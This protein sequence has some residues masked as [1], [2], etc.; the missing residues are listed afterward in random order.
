M[1]EN[2]GMKNK[3]SVIVNEEKKKS[4][5]MSGVDFLDKNIENHSAEILEK[6]GA[7]QEWIDYNGL[8]DAVIVN[9]N[10]LHEKE[11]SYFIKKKIERMLVLPLDDLDEES[12]RVFIKSNWDYLS[13][14]IV[15]GGVI[16][17]RTGKCFEYEELEGLN[18]LNRN[19]FNE[20]DFERFFSLCRNVEPVIFS[21]Y[22]KDQYAFFYEDEDIRNNYRIAPVMFEG[23]LSSYRYYSRISGKFCALYDY[24]KGRVLKY[25][26][27]DAQTEKNIDDKKTRE[28]S[29]KIRDMEDELDYMDLKLV[30]EEFGYVNKYIYFR[31]KLSESVMADLDNKFGLTHLPDELD[32]DFFNEDEFNML[33]EKNRQEIKITE[34]KANLELLRKSLV[35]VLEER[36]MSNVNENAGFKLD[37]MSFISRRFSSGVP[38][39]SSERLEKYMGSR[40]WLPDDLVAE[41]EKN[42]PVDFGTYVINDYPYYNKK[43]FPEDMH[44]IEIETADHFLK[45][46][47]EVN[48]RIEK[49]LNGRL[50]LKEVSLEDI[51]AEE[52]FDKNNL[53]DNK[54]VE[55]FANYRSLMNL[56]TRRNI[57]VEFGIKLSDFSVREQ[58]QFVNFLSAKSEKEVIMV[59][60]FL[61]QGA[62]KKNRLKAFLSLESGEKMSEVIMNIG[63]QLKNNPEIADNLF[64]EYAKIVDGAQKTAEEIEKIYAEIFLKKSLDRNELMRTILKKASELLVD[65]QKELK[66]SNGQDADEV[67]KKIVE[68]LKSQEKNQKKY[69]ADI[70]QAL[71]ILIKKSGDIFLAKFSEALEEINK[72]DETKR[73][74]FIVISDSEKAK[75]FEE[76]AK[77]DGL[78][79][80]TVDTVASLGLG[81]GELIARALKFENKLKNLIDSLKNKIEKLIYG[82]ESASLPGNYQKFL[83]SDIENYQPELP[84]KEN[85]SYLPVGISSTPPSES[86]IHQKPIDALLWLLWLNNQGQK[87]EL[88][89]ADTIQRYNYAVLP[90]NQRPA[91]PKSAAVK[92]GQKDRQWYLAVK[93]VLGLENIIMLEDTEFSRYEE[94]VEK[95]PEV[96]RWLKIISELEKTS[97]A[98]AR[99]ISNLVE[100]TIRERVFQELKTEEDKWQASRSI[101][102]YGKEELAFILT[103]PE[104]KISHKKE[105]RYDLLARIIPIYQELK[106]RAGEIPELSQNIENIRNRDQV[107]VELSLQLGYFNDFSEVYYEGAKLVTVEKHI[108]DLKNQSNNPEVEKDKKI[109]SQVQEKVRQLTMEAKSLKVTLK[110]V[111]E[112]IEK[113][114]K[115]DLFED[116]VKKLGISTNPKEIALKW[117]ELGKKL[118]QEEW[119]EKLKLPKFYYPKG[120]TSLSFDV[121]EKGEFMNFREPYSTYKGENE[122][123]LAIESNQMIASTNLLAAAKVLVLSEKGQRTYFEKVLR[124]LIVNYYIATSRSKE[125]AKTRFQENFKGVTNISEVIELIQKKIIWPL[126]LELQAV[127]V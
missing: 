72:E 43:S 52:G 61:N 117:K 35:T 79:Y 2:D 122:E 98:M 3:G 99:A 49:V 75:G 73:T 76:K 62:G 22:E 97:P 82:C 8:S 85:G 28:G 5:L 23:L 26:K 21:N 4:Y 101:D 50:E 54:Y 29:F 123:E 45:L 9:L 15:S 55:I 91:D 121:G 67:V 46:N 14:E 68:R 104:Q 116:A 11:K 17:S 53:G 48:V 111:E 60:N 59:K 25:F 90:E 1:I 88:L 10:E 113:E 7:I 127:K 87:T 19:S 96:Q 80:R 42:T 114:A 95:N 20:K 36:Y 33:F 93:K 44:E 41:F 81:D 115:Y 39:L 37:D 105:I 83:V 40:H 31:R 125:E 47:K 108:R 6:L 103:F 107:L 110:L 58:V 70:Q 16:N 89:V 86:E 126:E 106:N 119:F 51:L 57:D 27:L 94:K 30:L 13:Q 24:G 124:P 71:D 38:R 32:K 66:M 109:I 18:P 69:L 63:W 84:E 100:P 77:K 92:N 74:K 112:R 64:S 12:K 120:I 34:N 65:A 56:E 102:M 78:R 118:S